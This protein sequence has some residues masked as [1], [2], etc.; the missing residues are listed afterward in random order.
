[1]FSYDQGIINRNNGTTTTT[2]KKTR[3]KE[4]QVCAEVIQHQQTG[5]KVPTLTHR[6]L[7]T[8]C[9]FHGYRKMT[10]KFIFCIL[11]FTQELDIVPK[12]LSNASFKKRNEAKK[13]TFLHVFTSAVLAIN[14]PPITTLYNSILKK[15]TF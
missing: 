12:N 6:F 5:L 14:V 2:K 1:M 4:A 10:I 3:T 8:P 9:V 7:L 15:K 11:L 13:N